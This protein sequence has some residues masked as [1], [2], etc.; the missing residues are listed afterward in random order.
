M[1]IGTVKVKGKASCLAS[2]ADRRVAQAE[3]AFCGSALSAI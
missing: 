2:A 3:L 1:W